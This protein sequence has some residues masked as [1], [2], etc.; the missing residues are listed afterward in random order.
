MNWDSIL[1]VMLGALLAI[2]TTFVTTLFNDWR[3]DRAKRNRLKRFLSSEL[4]I[5]VQRVDALLEVY[6]RTQSPDPRILTSLEH[7]FHHFKQYREVV[8]DLELN[9]SQ[10]VILFYDGIQQSVELV[11]SMLRLAQGSEYID[12]AAQE[13]E[14]QM[15]ELETVSSVGAQ[16]VAELQVDL[17]KQ[18]SLRWIPKRKRNDKSHIL[19]PL[20]HGGLSDDH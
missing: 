12:Y 10:R 5:C 18:H 14:K 11:L 20:Q 15:T 4:P 1:P 19:T 17:S 9:M 8:Y 6:A 3:E 16:L 7:T 2:L 13:I